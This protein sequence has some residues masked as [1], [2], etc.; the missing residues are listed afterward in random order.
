VCVQQ[1]GQIIAGLSAVSVYIVGGVPN[2][3]TAATT[4]T[5]TTTTIM[6]ALVVRVVDKTL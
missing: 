2:Y 1:Y 5:T 6:R 4:T 3:I